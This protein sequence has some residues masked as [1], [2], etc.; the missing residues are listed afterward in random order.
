M[1]LAVLLVIFGGIFGYKWIEQKFTADYLASYQPPP[2]PI[3]ATAVLV[4]T[5]DR[6]LRATGSTVA[7]RE[8]VVSSEADGVISAIHFD[9]GDSVARGDLLIELDSQAELASL[10]SY[11]ARLHLA[12]INFDRDSKMLS[13][14]LISTDQF[15]RSKAELDEIKALVEQTQAIIAQK[16][17]RA[18]FDGKLGIRQVSEGQY[19]AAGEAAVTLQSLDPIFVDFSFPEQHLPDVHLGQALT[20]TIKAYPGRIFT[21]RVTAIDARVDERTRNIAVRGEAPNPEHQLLPG[22]FADVQ[23][24]LGKGEPAMVVPE[25][26]ISHSLYGQAVF[27]IVSRLSPAGDSELVVR[28]RPVET[29]AEQ[30]A[31]VQIEGELTAGAVVVINGQ[32]KLQEGTR[33]KIVPGPD[34]SSEDVPRVEGAADPVAAPV[35]DG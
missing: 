31:R 9:S 2:V 23:L 1:M 17:V 21:G 25:T 5:W 18:P 4:E 22:M 20:F 26:A 15:D 28:R 11:Q 32:N 8:I 33:V 30:G 13:R 29:G 24:N 12:E 16:S 10:K 34:Q 35:V 6:Q 27:E 19:L 14:S 7:V 3:S